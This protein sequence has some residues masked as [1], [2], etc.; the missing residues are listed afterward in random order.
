[1]QDK[2]Q[3]SNISDKSNKDKFLEIEDD[4]DIE[5]IIINCKVFKD[6]EIKYRYLRNNPISVSEALSW[7]E[8]EKKIFAFIDFCLEFLDLY[9]IKTIIRAYLDKDYSILDKEL[10]NS[11][12][13]LLNEFIAF[14]CTEK[15][16]KGAIFCDDEFKPIFSDKVESFKD[17]FEIKDIK[18][19]NDNVIGCYIKA[20][21]HY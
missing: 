13:D 2:K 19:E 12:C 11:L 18:D 15:K 7:I 10:K 6:N 1:M 21:I 9:D 17:D 16:K 4:L 5:S 20:V 3:N 8:E 14:E